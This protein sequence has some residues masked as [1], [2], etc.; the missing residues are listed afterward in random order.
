MRARAGRREVIDVALGALDHEV[1]VEVGAEVAQRLDRVGPIVIGGTKWPSMT[2]TWMTSAPAATTS[3]DLLA[4]PPE[5]GGQ[6]RWGD[7]A[8]HTSTSIEP[9]QWL[10]VSDGGARHAHDR[11]VLAA[12]RA[13]R[14]QLEAVQAVDAAVAP[15]QVRSAAARARRRTGT[16]RA[17]G[18]ARS[19]SAR[20]YRSRRCRRGA[21]ACAALGPLD[22]RSSARRDA[23]RRSTRAPRR[24][25]GAPARRGEQRV[26]LGGQA[27]DRLAGVARQRRS[28]CERSVPRPLHGGSSSTRSKPPRRPRTSRRRRPDDA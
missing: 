21:G 5:V 20:Q 4:Q 12:V 28:G 7:P 24:A 3:C 2:S 19:A 10:Q 6:D 15:G 13:D 22:R 27:L 25:A 9:P 17:R 18:H 14:A 1:H 8:R 23:C 16:R 11:R 26:L